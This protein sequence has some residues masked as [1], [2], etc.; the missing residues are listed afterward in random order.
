MTACLAPSRSKK[1]PVGFQPPLPLP[2]I[3]LITTCV[4]RLI[5]QFLIDPINGLPGKVLFFRFTFSNSHRKGRAPS[6]T[7]PTIAIFLVLGGLF[8]NVGGPFGPFVSP[9]ACA[10]SQI[11]PQSKATRAVFKAKGLLST[12]SDSKFLSL[13]RFSSLF[14]P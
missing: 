11:A 14:P 9:T 4:E 6:R 12:S 1:A 3:P 8:K 13:F 2:R 10:L 5:G 7:Q